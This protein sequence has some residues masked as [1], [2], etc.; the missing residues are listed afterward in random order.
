MKKQYAAPV[1]RRREKLA[2]V[3]E[4]AQPVSGGNGIDRGT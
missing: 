4:A 3:T 2:K 1:L